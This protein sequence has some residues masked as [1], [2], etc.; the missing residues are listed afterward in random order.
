MRQT[1]WL[2]A[3]GIVALLR[4]IF[5]RLQEDHDNAQFLVEGYSLSGDKSESASGTN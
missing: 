2:C 5:A 4:I 1:G 3:C